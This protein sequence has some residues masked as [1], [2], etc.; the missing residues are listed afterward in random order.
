MYPSVRPSYSRDDSMFFKNKESHKK[1]L[2]HDCLIEQSPTLFGEKEQLTKT[3]HIIVSCGSVITF[4]SKK[5]K[6]KNQSSLAFT[7]VRSSS[8]NKKTLLKKLLHIHNCLIEQ[9][10][11]KLDESWPYYVFKKQNK[12]YFVQQGEIVR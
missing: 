5:K 9:P 2:T 10:S 8:V 4:F 12:K 1:S 11:N 7:L 6:K 3:S